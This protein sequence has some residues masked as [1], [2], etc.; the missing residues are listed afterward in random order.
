M[1]EMW[2][3]SPER[4]GTARS[5]EVLGAKLMGLNFILKPLGSH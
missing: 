2:E 4:E 1:G 3:M 5:S